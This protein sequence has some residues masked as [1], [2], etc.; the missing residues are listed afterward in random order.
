MPQTSVSSAPAR[1]YAGQRADSGIKHDDSFAAEGTI[2][3]GQPVLRGTDPQ[4]QV[5]AIADSDTVDGST[6][7]GFALLDTSRPFDATAPIADDD[8]VAVRRQGRIYVQVSDAVSAGDP[9]YVGNLTAQLGDIEGAAGTG[10]VLV[11]GARF[12]TSAAS[13]EVAILELNLS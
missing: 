10:L 13:G 6:L 12:V 1:G 11:S 2:V 7:A 5:I 8:S 9:C 4:T 3:A